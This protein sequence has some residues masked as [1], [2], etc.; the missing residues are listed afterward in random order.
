MAEKRIIDFFHGASYI[1]YN[2]FKEATI[3]K[4]DAS[5]PRNYCALDAMKR[6]L[7]QRFSILISNAQFDRLLQF[8]GNYDEAKRTGL[9]NW[10]DIFKKFSEINPWK[11]FKDNCEVVASRQKSRRSSRSSRA[12]SFSSKTLMSMKFDGTNT[13]TIKEETKDLSD[14]EED[15]NM[16]TS[17]D[18]EEEE[19]V[20][21]DSSEDEETA[22]KVKKDSDANA[23][24]KLNTDIESFEFIGEKR[25]DKQRAREVRKR[26]KKVER[27][28]EKLFRV[29]F[30][31]MTKNLAIVDP[32]RTEKLGQAS[33]RELMSRVGLK[34]SEEDVAC[35]WRGFSGVEQVP[36]SNIVRRF[37]IPE[38][39]SRMRKFNDR[40]EKGRHF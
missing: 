14:G 29:K 39:F 33:F 15:I 18:D 38:E 26:E 8:L 21:I 23:T 12:G 34:L 22:N 19:L 17:D 31:S 32:G 37:V 5:V 40:V 35:V 11:L 16:F 2:S 1:A 25:S 30:H 24:K 28:I 20:V 13:G 4:T 6:L 9:A 3:D 27:T 7:E 36:F 10:T